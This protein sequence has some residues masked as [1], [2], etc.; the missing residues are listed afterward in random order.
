MDNSCCFVHHHPRTSLFCNLITSILHL[1]MF[2]TKRTLLI[3]KKLSIQRDNLTESIRLH[4]I[5][6]IINCIAINKT[7][8]LGIVSMQVKEKRQSLVLVQILR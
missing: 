7:S 3:L 2:Q 4:L 1:H 5:H 6:K 8:L